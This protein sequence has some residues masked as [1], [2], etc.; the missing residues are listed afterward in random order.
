MDKNKLPKLSVVICTVNR[1]DMIVLCLKGLAKQVEKNFE[2]IIID[3][4]LDDSLEA[5]C[6]R[7]IK[8]LKLKRIRV[9]KQ[10]LPYQRNIGIANSVGFI[11]VFIDDDAI[12]A[13]D[14][15]QNI[16]ES[17]ARNRRTVVL[18][19]KILS[20]SKDYISKFS[21][22]LFDYGPKAKTVTTV[23]GVNSAFNLTRLKKLNR[24]FR[25]KIFD[26]RFTTAADDTE[27]CFYIGAK[28]GEI[29]YEPTVVVWHHFRRS[30]IKFIKRQFDYAHGDLIASTKASYRPYSLVEDYLFPLNKKSTTLLL[31]L[32]L[33][34]IV[35]K[36]SAVFIL[37]NG[38]VWTPLIL[39]REASYTIGLYITLFQKAAGRL[40][41]YEI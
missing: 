23:T 21:G 17:F 24:N 34:L 4:G 6:R 5:I 40:Y 22:T 3:A 35:F 10:N 29:K 32:L 7:F 26:E 18:G 39:I 9:K 8:S 1:Q 37:R 20:A 2:V 19:G 15:T 30:L 36:R 28:G 31:P 25:K 11:V 41:Y 33:P 27:A 14:W 38:L 13:K 12:P 16:I